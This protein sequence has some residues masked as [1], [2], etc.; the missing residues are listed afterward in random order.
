M[1]GFTPA[2]ATRKARNRAGE[3]NQ[4]RDYHRQGPA[5]RNKSGL[6]VIHHASPKSTSNAAKPI[7]R[8]LSVVS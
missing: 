4:G 7:A 2:N 8:L 3:N 1:P 5:D 6:A